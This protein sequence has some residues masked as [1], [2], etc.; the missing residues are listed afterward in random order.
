MTPQ[1]DAYL[2]FP[3]T[4]ADAMQFY[5]KTLGARIKMMMT[6]AEMPKGPGSPPVPPGSEHL[7]MHCALEL[8]GRTLMASDW[9]SPQPYPGIHGVAIALNYPDPAEAKRV[10]A[11][12]SEG[13]AVSMPMQQTFWIE[14][15]GMANDRFGT[16]WMVNG[17][18]PAPMPG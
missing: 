14:A 1:F 8:D 5:E 2:F 11:A 16:P 13:G 15:F 17:G 7:V 3:G 18:A 9:L 6:H 4:C 12:L 10:F